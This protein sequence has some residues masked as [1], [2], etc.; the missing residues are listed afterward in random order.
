VTLTAPAAGS[1][2][3]FG[4]GIVLSASASD[5][6]ANGG[7]ATIQ[8][9]SDG[10]PVS[11]PLPAD[12]QGSAAFVWSGTSE[13]GHSLSAVAVDFSGT[14]AESAA[15]AVS[16]TPSRPRLAWQHPGQNGVFQSDDAVTLRVEAQP[17]AA[18]AAVVSVEFL[19]RAP[20]QSIPVSLGS[21][22]AA[23]WQIAW[24]APAAEG[25]WELT[26]LATDTAGMVHSESITVH[27]TPDLSVPPVLSILSP[28]DA[29]TITAP[30][31]ITGT[32]SGVTLQNYTLQLR[33]VLPDNGGLW[34]TLAT[35]A[36]G[37]TESALGTLNPT[38]LENGPYEL[39]LMAD[40]WYG[41]TVTAPPVFVLLD[42]TD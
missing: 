1:E 32:V 10:Q 19:A 18:G 22:T 31:S 35:G 36:A 29:A 14:S 2:F 8:F 42:G 9:L 15:A 40:Q 11:A 21:D 12:G 24:T 27:V 6:D 5:P 28:A 20:G 13:G 23:P 41:G 34:R 37:I 16:V 25:A 3:E 38:L 7:I 33:P 39:R 26:A 17:G 30:V 4:Q